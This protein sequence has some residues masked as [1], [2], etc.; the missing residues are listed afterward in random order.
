MEAY[1]TPIFTTVAIAFAAALILTAAGKIFAVK[2][3]E[4]VHE[5]SEVP[6]SKPA[7]D[8]PAEEI[9]E[10]EYDKLCSSAEKVDLSGGIRISDFRGL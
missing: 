9:T 6:A 5:V 10:D 7:E 2:S 8:D 1:L 4:E 3:E